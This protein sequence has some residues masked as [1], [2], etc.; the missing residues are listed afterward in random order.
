MKQRLSLITI[1]GYSGCVIDIEENL[2]ELLII[3][4]SKWTPREM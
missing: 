3:P 2:W 4:S 1:G